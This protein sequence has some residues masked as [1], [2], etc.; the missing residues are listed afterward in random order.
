M[1]KAG[2]NP[3]R[4]DLVNAIN[5]G[6]PQGPSVA[7][8]AY[9]SSDH[10]GITGAY[11][12]VIKNGVDRPA[13]PVQV[14]DTSRHRRGHDRT[15]APSRPLRPAAYRR[16]D[17]AL[18]VCA[19]RSGQPACEQGPGCASGARRAVGVLG[20]FAAGRR[21]VRGDDRP[22]AERLL[23]AAEELFGERSYRQTTRG[24]D[25]RPGR[26]RDRQLLRALRVQ[27]RDLRR[28][29]PPDQ[30]RPAGRD[31]QGHRAVRPASGTGNEPL[32]GVLRDAVQAARGST[33]SCA[34]PSSSSP[35]CSAST[36]SGWPAA[37]RA[38]CGAPSWPARWTRTTTPRSSPTCTQASATSSACA[39]PTGPRAA[40]CPT[41]C[42]KTCSACWPA[43]CRPGRAASDV[44]PGR[45]QHPAR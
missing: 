23:S 33:A 12:G 9:S 8:Y 14:T 42:S 36:T 32:P 39:G 29:G 34:S 25:L 41:T 22:P 44:S 30:R 18:T 40:R 27:D 38:A 17:G 5:G 35:A 28:G 4:A 16:P 7:P 45:T 20:P 10:A 24:R 31:A 26:H 19:P 6:L 15:A 3:T 11:I 37:T 21:H 43:A 2:R 13:G 1:F